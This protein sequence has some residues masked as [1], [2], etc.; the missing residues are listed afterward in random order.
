MFYKQTSGSPSTFCIKVS[1]HFFCSKKKFPF[2]VHKVQLYPL[3]KTLKSSFT[4]EAGRLT[5][6][7]TGKNRVTSFTSFHEDMIIPKPLSPNRSLQIME[8]VYLPQRRCL[9]SV[10]PSMST[11]FVLNTKIQ[12]CKTKGGVS[13]KASDW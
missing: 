6:V 2:S 11:Y 5:A 8:S 3:I 1:Q 9:P 12:D 10:G 13:A 7:I 4:V